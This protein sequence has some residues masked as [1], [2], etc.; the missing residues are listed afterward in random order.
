MAQLKDTLIT[1]GLRVTDTT[2]TNVLQTSAIKAPVDSASGTIGLGSNGQVLTSDGTN[3]YW[4]SDILAANDAMV[5]KGTLGTGGTVT[6]LPNSDYSAGWTYRVATAG[7]YAGEYCEVGDLIIAVKDY[8]SPGAN[9]DWAKIEHNID[10]AIFT[11]STNG[12]VNTLTENRLIYA[13]GDNQVA[14]SVV[15]VEGD[16]DIK[17]SNKIR[18]Y[19]FNFN[20][21]AKDKTDGWRRICKV[22]SV[23]QYQHWLLGLTGLWS[24]EAPTTALIAVTSMSTTIGMTLLSSCY[25]DH[26]K[27][28]RLKNISSN[29][30]WLDIY[31]SG[32]EGATG[33]WGDINFSFSGNVT[34]SEIQ[35]STDINTDTGG[36]ELTLRTIKDQPVFT[37]SDNDGS[38]STTS[39]FTHQDQTIKLPAT[40]KA[41]LAGTATQVS[42]NLTLKI[43]S[44]TTEGTSLYTYNGSA[45]KTLDIKAG[46]GVTLTAAA[47]SVTITSTDEKVK[48]SLSSNN[49]EY[50]IL[51]SN[52]VAPTSGNADYTLYS[53][54]VTINPSTST[55]TSNAYKLANED[56]A[57]AN[58]VYNATTNAIDFNF[59]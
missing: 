27:K 13:T 23:S 7:T 58:I 11:G 9:T 2:I 43:A 36:A 45:A 3:T 52:A 57:K 8:V 55:I 48:Q 44:G 50:R 26:I 51:T 33:N 54:Y 41:T 34:I 32:V 18:F 29:T 39:T 24:S 31:I 25:I 28:I 14:S 17:L 15:T 47:G 56:T 10:G 46:T 59:I 20:M 38:H 6:N 5:F 37:L 42:K 49:L 35:T 53:N 1:G 21:G 30:Y 40:I 4:S 16:N 19:N 12:T 22:T